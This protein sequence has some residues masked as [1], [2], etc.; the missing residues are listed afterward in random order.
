MAPIRT[1]SSSIPCSICHFNKEEN[2][3]HPYFIVSSPHTVW[4]VVCYLGV[5]GHVQALLSFQS[6]G[7]GRITCQYVITNKYIRCPWCPSSHSLSLTSDPIVA[8]AGRCLQASTYFTPIMSHLNYALWVF[9][10]LFWGFSDVPK[11]SNCPLIRHEAL[12]GSTWL[13]VSQ[14]QP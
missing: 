13:V 12:L 9:L 1:V 3:L 8:A 4:W 14:G 10:F 5:T 2:P 7:N 11:A 6:Q